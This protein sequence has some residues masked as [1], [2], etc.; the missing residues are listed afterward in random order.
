MTSHA[1]QCVCDK[2]PIYWAGTLPLLMCA[3]VLI[4]YIAADE[5]LI[6]SCIFSCNNNN[7]AIVKDGMGKQCY[8]DKQQSA[9][10]AAQKVIYRKG[11][12]ENMK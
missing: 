6:S 3:N 9:E 1:Q 5:L 2:L 11:K 12:T 7:V 8:V 10:M 4:P